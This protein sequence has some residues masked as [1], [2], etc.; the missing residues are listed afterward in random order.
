ML[1][2]VYFSSVTLFYQKQNRNQETIFMLTGIIVTVVVAGLFGFG[3]YL[4][5]HTS[6]TRIDIIEQE[7]RK[8][9]LE[10]YKWL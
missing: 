9:E 2:E 4:L 3:A 8:R 5:A 6:D 1:L 10:I 7:K